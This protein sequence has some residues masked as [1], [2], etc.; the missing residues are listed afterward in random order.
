[1]VIAGLNLTGNFTSLKI[2]LNNDPTQILF[3]ISVLLLT[4]RVTVLVYSKESLAPSP[5]ARM[6]NYFVVYCQTRVR[7]L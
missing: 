6:K 1:M 4:G 7:F 5:P 3:F 2:Q